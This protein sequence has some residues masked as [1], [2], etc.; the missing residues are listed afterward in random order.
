MQG[1]K[2]KNI[3][4]ALFHFFGGLGMTIFG[5]SQRDQ[6][7]TAGD[8][9]LTA[10][11]IGVFTVW[12]LASLHHLAKFGFFSFLKLKRVQF[13][14]YFLAFLVFTLLAVINFSTGLGIF[15]LYLFLSIISL[16]FFCKVVWK[17][18]QELGDAIP[19]EP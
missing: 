14:L 13:F 19:E 3:G 4:W 5:L 2:G 1:K 17:I 15:S 11:F 7:K 10:M 18:L 9:V 12:T 16:V 8:L 6:I